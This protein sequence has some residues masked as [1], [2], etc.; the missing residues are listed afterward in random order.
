MNQVRIT[1]MVTLQPIAMV[2]PTK[3]GIYAPSRIEQK[4]NNYLSGIFDQIF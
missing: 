4:N 2:T 3:E 1:E